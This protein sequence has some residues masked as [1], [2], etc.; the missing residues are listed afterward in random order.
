MSTVNV[1]QI[2]WSGY[3]QFEG[4]FFRG[5]PSAKYIEP[6]DPTWNDKVL[7]TITSTEGGNFAAYNGYDRCIST[8]GLIQWCEAG[9]YAVSDM[10]GVAAG[11]GLSAISEL[12]EALAAANVEFKKNAKGNWRFFFKDERGEVDGDG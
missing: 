11:R 10:L 1:S 9:M 5:H 3:L 8:S 4:P 12:D 2:G 6:A 7:S